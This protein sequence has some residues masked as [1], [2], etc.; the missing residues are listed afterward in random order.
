MSKEILSLLL[1]GANGTIQHVNKGGAHAFI[2]VRPFGTFFLLR[3]KVN[4]K[5]NLSRIKIS[6]Y[7]SQDLVSGED[8]EAKI[9]ILP[10]SLYSSILYRFIN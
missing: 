5:R 8:L 3:S 9:Y 1:I 4:K 6:S 10:F 2:L 7:I